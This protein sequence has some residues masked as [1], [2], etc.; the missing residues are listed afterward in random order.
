MFKK[1]Q[2]YRFSI[3]SS[4]NLSISEIDKYFSF[5]NSKKISQN[6]YEVIDTSTNIGVLKL[7]LE[8]KSVD[9]ELS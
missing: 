2:K 8:E 1:P 9:L 5:Y 7:I 3:N 6:Q 4:Q